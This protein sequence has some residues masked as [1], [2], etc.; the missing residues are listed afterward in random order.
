[1]LN[2]GYDRPE[3]SED[4]DNNIYVYS[5]IA[6]HYV[7]ISC[8][9][10][11]RTFPRLRFALIVGIGGGALTIRNNIRL[12]NIVVSQLKDRFGG[13]IQ[14]NLAGH[15]YDEYD[16]HSVVVRL[17]RHNHRALYVYYGNIALGNSVLKDAIIRDIFARDLELNILCFKIE[18]TGLIN[19]ILCLIV[20]G[21]YDYCDSYKNNK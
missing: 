8:L 13:V 7:V 12:G 2:E 19:N 5:R 18:A 21:I 20:R 10:A 4:K 3:I 6:K 11:V 14:Y 9:L 17:E 1:M 15:N 16:S